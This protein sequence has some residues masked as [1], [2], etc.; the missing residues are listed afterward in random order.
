[1]EKFVI[2]PNFRPKDATAMSKLF[3]T[4]VVSELSQKKHPKRFIEL[5]DA[6]GLYQV[7]KYNVT[8]KGAYDTAFTLLKKRDYRHEYI[9]KAALYEKIQLG[10]HSLNT[11]CMINEFRVGRSKADTVLFNGTATAYEI[12]SERDT[13]SR[14]E[15]QVSD[16][17]KVFPY[18]NVIAGENHIQAL[19]SLFPK[20][21]GILALSRRYSITTIRPPSLDY[22]KIDPQKILSCIRI[23]EAKSMLKKIGVKIPQV[24]N[25]KIYDEISNAF[26]QIEIDV[27][28]KCMVETLKQSRSLA[29]LSEFLSS[30][31]TP[32]HSV[33]ISAKLNASEKLS[34]IDTLNTPIYRL[35]T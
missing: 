29:N 35:I 15:D 21:I 12:K 19:E 23:S 30:V 17:Y 2:N 13:L 6:S 7:L 1:M 25:T 3:S 18:V 34:F 26:N 11:A 33:V 32:L 24:P 27:L 14:L 20:N 28:H 16:Y 22:D 10:Y 5:L 9:Y 4:R 31:P 8:V